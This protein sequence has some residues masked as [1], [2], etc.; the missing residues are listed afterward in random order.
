MVHQ[1]LAA[2][3]TTQWHK[4]ALDIEEEDSKRPGL[5]EG[6]EYAD[7][8]NL[9]KLEMDFVDFVIH[10]DMLK[11]FYGLTKLTVKQVS[12][13]SLFN[14]LLLEVLNPDVHTELQALVCQYK[15]NWVHWG[16][17][18]SEDMKLSSELLAKL[19]MWPNLLAFPGSDSQQC[20]RNRIRQTKLE[21]LAARRLYIK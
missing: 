14:S 4:L 19:H 13:G 8:G 17:T 15:Y 18:A 7:W 3:P 5:F 21:D 12:D 16:S 6:L 20:T 11:H 2:I 9:I 1:I 10:Y